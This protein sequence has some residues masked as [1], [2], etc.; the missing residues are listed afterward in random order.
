MLGP[1]SASYVVALHGLARVVSRAT[2]SVM[3]RGC[4]RRPRVSVSHSCRQMS[5]MTNMFADVETIEELIYR[6]VGAGSSCWVG[7]TGDLT[8]DTP[9]AARVGHDALTRLNE[10]LGQADL[11]RCRDFFETGIAL[12]ADP[13][14][15]I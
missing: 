15:R 9:L 12:A 2:K 4:G 6:L 13:P 8:F 3:E 14:P 11:H 5:P 10:L 7:S 1:P